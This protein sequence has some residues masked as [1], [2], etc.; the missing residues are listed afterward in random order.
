VEHTGKRQQTPHQCPLLRK[1]ER[2]KESKK[3]IKK[4]KQQK[5][6]K[7]QR[8]NK[9]S[10]NKNHNNHNRL[11]KPNESFY[12]FLFFL[13][14]LAK[15]SC[16]CEQISSGRRRWGVGFSGVFFCYLFILFLWGRG[17]EVVCGRKFIS[18]S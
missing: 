16:H 5:N 14:I 10:N 6:K 7:E 1:K 4:T 18:E 11:Q 15:I 8:N 2:K 9:I 12:F 17:G 13:Q 3:I